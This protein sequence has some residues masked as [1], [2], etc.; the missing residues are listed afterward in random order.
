MVSRNVV[1]RSKCIRSCDCWD[2]F[3][4]LAHEFTYE[5]AETVSDV[6]ICNVD[7]LLGELAHINKEFRTVDI[8]THDDFAVVRILCH[9]QEFEDNLCTVRI[10]KCEVC[11]KRQAVSC[12]HI[13]CWEVDAKFEPEVCNEHVEIFFKSDLLLLS[14]ELQVEVK[15]HLERDFVELID[16]HIICFVEVAWQYACAAT[17]LNSE[18][19]QADCKCKWI[20]TDA[21]LE[22]IFPIELQEARVRIE[23]QEL[24]CGDLLAR[25]HVDKHEHKTLCK[26]DLEAFLVSI[27]CADNTADDALQRVNDA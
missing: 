15:S 5:R 4:D 16:G 2:I 22:R 24:V 6:S 1:C 8:D 10:V 12:I 26:V 3:A 21:E 19:R 17:Q 27:D 7:C 20:N 11:A 18:L 25:D 9:I 23:L 13:H 14:L